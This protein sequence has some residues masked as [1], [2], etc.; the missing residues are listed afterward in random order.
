MIADGVDAIIIKVAA[1]G[2]DPDVHLGLRLSA[3]VDH[4][5]LMHIKYGL[6]VC[7]EGGEFETFVLDC[8]LFRKRIVIDEMEMIIHSND[9]FARVGYLRLKKLHCVDKKMH[10]NVASKVILDNNTQSVVDII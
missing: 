3:I 1:L 7:G 10:G 8:S 6:N 2:L 4:L 9:A 5:K